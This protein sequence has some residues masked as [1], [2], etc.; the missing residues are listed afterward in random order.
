M[1]THGRLSLLVLVLLLASCGQDDQTADTGATPST[2]STTT[3]APAVDP[4]TTST[5]PGTTTTT[6]VP[7][8]TTSVT[9]A[10]TTPETTTTV[11]ASTGQQLP[12]SFGSVGELRSL[13]DV[14]AFSPLDAQIVSSQSMSTDED[15]AASMGAPLESLWDYSVS[16]TITHFGD[17]TV[18]DHDDGVREVERHGQRMVLLEPGKWQ[19]NGGSP[20]L[21][22][23]PIFDWT[24][25]Q[26]SAIECIEFDPEVIGLEQIAGATTLHLR[27]AGDDEALE[28]HI[29]LDVWIGEEG[30]VM[31][32]MYEQTS[33]AGGFFWDWEVTT[34]DVEPTGPLPPGW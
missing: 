15:Y 14:S 19:D 32:S 17:V 34:L 10:S 20:R 8:T 27:C 24:E 12:G 33:D 22:L 26:S 13:V 3:I 28:L 2:S 25:F 29:S 23:G 18:W 4:T 16:A 21:P 9:T 5:A 6:R 11:G 31:K 7:A 1:A 30:Q